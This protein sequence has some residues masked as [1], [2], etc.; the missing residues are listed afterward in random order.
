[1]RRILYRL[2]VFLDSTHRVVV[3]CLFIDLIPRLSQPSQVQRR[4]AFALDL[5]SF[6]TG[7]RTMHVW[8]YRN[9][10]HRGLARRPKRKPAFTTA[11]L[12]QEGQQHE[13]E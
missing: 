1:M 2:V 12:T 6:F 9:R 8:D 11:R 4:R 3:I 13:E 7:E 10:R 5:S